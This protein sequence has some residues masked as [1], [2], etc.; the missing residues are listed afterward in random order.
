M[1]FEVVTTRKRMYGCFKISEY[2]K[3]EK[4]KMPNIVG[5]KETRSKNRLKV[6]RDK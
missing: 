3:T 2:L 4:G 5:E 1:L 6:F